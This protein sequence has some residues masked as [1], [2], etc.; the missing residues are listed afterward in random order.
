MKRSSLSDCRYSALLREFLLNQK[1]ISRKIFDG[2]ATTLFSSDSMAARVQAHVTVVAT[3][4]AENA[5]DPTKARIRKRAARFFAHALA[6]LYSPS[7]MIHSIEALSLYIIEQSAQQK[8]WQESLSAKNSALVLSQKNQ[9]HYEQLLKN[10]ETHQTQ[11]RRLSRQLLCAQEDER[12]RISRELRDVI[13]QTLTGINIQLATLKL[14]SCNDPKGMLR[15]IKNTQRLVEISVAIVHQFACELRPAVIDVLG[16]VPALQNYLT[17]FSARTGIHSSIKSSSPLTNL[18]VAQC[19]CLFRVA[20]EALT[21][22]ARHSNAHH[23]IIRL[24]K[25]KSM[26]TMTIH[27]NGKS[28]CVPTAAQNQSGKH[29]GLLGMRERVEMMGG[30]F[31]IESCPNHGT[32]I[33]AKIPATNSQRK[34]NKSTPESK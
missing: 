32:K 1:T 16:L 22:V 27:D 29:L 3:C 21:N 9:F 34:I 8:A 20:E 23:V 19:T 11:L 31:R 6:S 28:F 30:S 4:I 26:I 25:V 13:A 14:Q 5:S 33:S 15:S 12:R 7:A 17:K 18:E 2:E 24:S 10:S